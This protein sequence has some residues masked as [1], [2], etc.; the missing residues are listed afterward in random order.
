M[1]RS[2]FENKFASGVEEE[3]GDVVMGG[4]W[5]ENL[6]NQGMYILLNTPET[7]LELS[8]RI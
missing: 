4:G 5:M 2:V 8:E 3:D 6:K 1:E 7:A